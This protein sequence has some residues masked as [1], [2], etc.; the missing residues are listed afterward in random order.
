M[1]VM[2]QEP[3]STKPLQWAILAILA[4]TVIVFMV[5]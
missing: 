4:I 5:K 2:K 1:S 3:K